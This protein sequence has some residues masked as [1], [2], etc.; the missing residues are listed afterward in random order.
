MRRDAAKLLGLTALVGLVV[1]ALMAEA[2][3]AP[4]GFGGAGTDIRSLVA[5][6]WTFVGDALRDGRLARW[7]PHIFTGQPELAGA[8]WGVLYPVQ[9]ALLLALP[10]RDAIL[11]SIWL[12]LCLTFAA[13]YLLSAA[14]LRTQHRP[15]PAAACSLGGLALLGSGV[16]MGHLH[17]GH[18]M[19]TQATPW[20]VLGAAAGLRALAGRRFGGPLAAASFALGILAGGIQVAPYAGLAALLVWA[21]AWPAVRPR[22]RAVLVLAG[23]LVVAAALAAGQ[24]VP[25]LELTAHSG[26]QLLGQIAPRPRFLLRGTDLLGLISPTATQD[27]ERAAFLGGP[28]VAL[29]LARLA[30]PAR[31]APVMLW[32]GALAAWLLGASVASDVV[33]ATPGLQ[34]LRVPARSVWV[35][36]TVLPLAAISALTLPTADR[37]VV[38]RLAAWICGLFA[39]I[40]GMAGG[41]LVVA[42][43]TATAGGALAWLAHRDSDK[44]RSLAVTSAA[45]VLLLGGATSFAPL[46]AERDLPAPLR[47]Q[48]VAAAP[49]F[50]VMTGPGGLWNLGM[51]HGYLHLG[52]YEPLMTA[53]AMHLARALATPPSAGRLF[54]IVPDRPLTPHRLWTRLGVRWALGND[55]A[56][57]RAWGA[58]G[59]RVAAAG[60]SALYRAGDAT[61]RAYFVACPAA[62]TSP[63]SALRRLAAATEPRVAVIEG[64][65]IEGAVI[66][67]AVIEA[68]VAPCATPGATA[69]VRIVRAEAERLDVLVTA[70][71]PGWLIVQDL[72]YPGWQA[73]VDG[74]AATMLHANAV[75]R[76]PRV[77]GG[78]HRVEMRFVA[79]NVTAG[80]GVSAIAWLLWLVWLLRLLWL[81]RSL[82]APGSALAAAT[83]GP[84]ASSDPAIA[85]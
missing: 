28:V 37:K 1:V 59:P 60:A 61:P 16:V 3:Q 32:L 21:S 50:R 13:G 46:R 33:A 74:E 17:A 23:W 27:W 38:V 81:R 42:M 14:W 12:H 70:S 31:A 72:L 39:L 4:L 83:S 43:L 55:A 56:A 67:G 22:G 45:L 9:A 63:A 15:T 58:W 57:R 35:I 53:R 2:L 75:G 84:A 47:T 18:L 36:V 7:N 80:L 48:F 68:A 41:G 71:A 52:G 6:H 11:A 85:R 76:A 82:A 78:A 19:L 54:A 66:E 62:A 29:A 77:S 8:Q 49:N 79:A 65:V 25:T 51:R 24:L 34:L 69:D 73:T 26:R 5:P 10:V 64:A 40:I 30:G 20:F 44:A